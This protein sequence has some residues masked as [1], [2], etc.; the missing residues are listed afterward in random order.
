MGLFA[1]W[2][3]RSA[4]TAGGKSLGERAIEAQEPGPPRAQPPQAPSALTLS[5]P[6]RLAFWRALGG[7]VIGLLRLTGLDQLRRIRRGLEGRAQA[8][9]AFL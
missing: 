2:P 6:A 7:A 1:T 3:R 4:A 9:D 8:L 5:F